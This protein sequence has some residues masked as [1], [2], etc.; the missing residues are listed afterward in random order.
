MFKNLKA[1]REQQGLKQEDFARQFGVKK[2]TYSNY[3]TGTTEPSSAFWIAVADH[4]RVSTDYLLGRTD[5]PR[6]TKYGGSDLDRK[7]AALDEQSKKLVDAVIRIESER[8]QQQEEKLKVIP[9]FVAAA[10][11]GE[12][13]DGVPFAEHTIPAQQRGDFAVRISGDS[14][15]PELHDGQIVLCLKRQPSNGELAVV[16]VNGCLLVKQALRSGGDLHL[17]SL[18]RARQDRDVDIYATGNDTVVCYGTVIRPI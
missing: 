6:G 14:M 8:G 9:L 3:E 1:L 17:R 2:S 12:P 11:P 13:V 10:G 7:Y 16:M 5:D 15:E 4:F 18:N